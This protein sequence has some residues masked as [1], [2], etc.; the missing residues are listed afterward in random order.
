LS[1]Y[2]IVILEAVAAQIRWCGS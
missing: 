2:K 1:H